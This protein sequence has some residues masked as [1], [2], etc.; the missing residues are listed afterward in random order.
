MKC[1][2]A[3][4]LVAPRGASLED[5]P[6][7]AMPGRDASPLQVLRAPLFFFAMI[8]RPLNSAQPSCMSFSRISGVSATLITAAPTLSAIAFGV[9]AGRKKPVH[10]VETRLG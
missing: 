5:L 10:T 3:L 7:A 1:L 8:V 4:V 6:P 9:F 2:A